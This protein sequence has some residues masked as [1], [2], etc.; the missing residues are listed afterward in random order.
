[1]QMALGEEILFPVWQWAV[2]Q[3]RGYPGMDDD[4][5]VS[6]LLKY[7]QI[8]QI[9]SKMLVN[10]LELGVVMV[11]YDKFGIKKNEIGMH[12]LCSWVAMA[13]FPV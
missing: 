10:A 11:G 13:I 4:T 7:D 9:H 2:V 8:K 6:A 3:I 5:L 12:L 1:M